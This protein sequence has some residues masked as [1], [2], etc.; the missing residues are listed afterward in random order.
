MIFEGGRMQNA[1][2]AEYKVPRFADLAPL[3]V[4]L[5]DK[6]ELA[7]AGAGETPLITVAPA[8]TNALSR[9]AGVRLR[10]L[11]LRMPEKG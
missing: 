5:L 7:S 11:P 10:E 9:V 4:Q 3:E 2:F 8:I 1:S 6:P